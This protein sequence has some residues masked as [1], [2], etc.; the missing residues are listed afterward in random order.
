MIG[1]PLLQPL[2]VTIKPTMIRTNTTRT[3]TKPP[4][5]HPPRPTRAMG[6]DCWLLEEPSVEAGQFFQQVEALARRLSRAPKSR[7]SEGSLD[8]EALSARHST[9]SLC[10]VA[11]GRLWVETFEF[12]NSRLQHPKFRQLPSCGLIVS[13]HLPSCA[14]SC[15]S[16]CPASRCNST[17]SGV[18]RVHLPVLSR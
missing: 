14:L 5:M 4:T 16:I 18:R 12:R 2:R 7:H 9:T 6:R 17:S 10:S 11:P 15:H 13:R 1:L 3:K 8:F